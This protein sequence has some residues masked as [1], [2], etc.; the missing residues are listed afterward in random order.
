M[1]HGAV[2]FGIQMQSR[3]AHPPALPRPFISHICTAQLNAHAV[4]VRQCYDRNL[5]SAM[6]STADKIFK[7]PK[8]LKSIAHFTQVSYSRLNFFSFFFSGGVLAGST[9]AAFL[10]LMGADGAPTVWL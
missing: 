3:G 10:L 7:K 4:A 9:A 2:I 1:K 5:Y 6:T 8:S